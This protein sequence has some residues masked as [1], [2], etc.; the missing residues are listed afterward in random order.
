MADL[1]MR[2]TGSKYYVALAN[3]PY[4]DAGANHDTC[5]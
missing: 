5:D 2:V 3:D 1:R 4:A